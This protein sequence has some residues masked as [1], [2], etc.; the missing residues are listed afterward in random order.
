MMANGFL[1]ARTIRQLHGVMRQGFQ[2]ALDFQEPDVGIALMRTDRETGEAVTLA[3]QRVVLT[4]QNRVPAM[5]GPA[6]SAQQ[7]ESA[8]VEAFAPFDVETG[9]EFEHAGQ[10]Y[11]VGEVFPEEFGIVS[12]SVR[13]W[14]GRA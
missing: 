14:S 12:A 11:V 5:A 10:R 8:T 4:F 3:P 13:R 9:D 2:T 6:S 1:D 7:A